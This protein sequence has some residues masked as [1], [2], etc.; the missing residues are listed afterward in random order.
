[1]NVMTD[2]RTLSP[3]IGTYGTYTVELWNERPTELVFF[4][5]RLQ[6]Y[7]TEYKRYNSSNNE[8]QSR[9]YTYHGCISSLLL[10]SVTVNILLHFIFILAT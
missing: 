5:F 2:G 3:K 4:F 6:M 9:L 10:L 1:M 8:N 7:L